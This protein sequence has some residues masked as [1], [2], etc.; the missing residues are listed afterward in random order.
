LFRVEGLIYLVVLP[1]LIFLQRQLPNRLML[2]AKANTLL[3]LAG[4]GLLLAVLLHPT[5]DIH[6][7]GRLGDPLILVRN[8]Y[9][10]L[11]HGLVDKAHTYGATV[12]GKFIS[13][14]GMDGLLLTL[15]YILIVKAA[16]ASGWMQMVLAIYARKFLKPN[17]LPAF[18]KVFAWLIAVGLTH[19]A[20]MLLSAF[21]LPKRYLMPLGFVIIVYAAFGLAELHRS[22]QQKPWRPFRKNWKFPL[23]AAVLTTQLG[24]MLWLWSPHKSY[25]LDAA[26]WVAAHATAGSRIYADSA[27]LRYYANADQS[28]RHDLVSVE[29]IQQLF[30][31]GQMSQYDYILVHASGDRQALASFLAG[32]SGLT[33]VAVLDH[34]RDAITVYR[35]TH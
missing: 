14:Y 33:T 11:A 25:E 35:L 29:E 5:L 2:F 26:N 21:L 17:Q 10:Q 22:W 15:I 16:T 20:F 18:Q 12:L 3:I 4:L 23:A 6:K 7:M 8:T 24:M 31:A 34:G 1:M 9:L 28:F 32:Q 13:S 19:A 30:T 27:R